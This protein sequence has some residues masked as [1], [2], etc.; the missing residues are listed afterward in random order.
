[1]VQKDDFASEKYL[2]QIWQKFQKSA[3]NLNKVNI[4]IAGVV[5]VNRL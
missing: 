3:T 1:M 2:D 4:M 5:L